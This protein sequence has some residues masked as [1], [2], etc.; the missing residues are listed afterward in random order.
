MNEEKQHEL[1]PMT[2][3]ELLRFSREKKDWTL[4]FV[5]KSINVRSEVLFSIESGETDH[6]PAV[7]L[8]GYIR[9]YARKLDIPS[10][11]IEPHLIEAKGAEPAVQPVFEKGPPRNP[12]DRWFKSTSYVLA[13]AVVI[14]LVWQFTNEA[15]RF[16]QGDPLLRAVGSEQSSNTSNSSNSDEGPE[17]TSQAQQ[18]QTVAKTHL[19]ASI[20][21]LNTTGNQSNS[22]T[23]LPAESAWAAVSNSDTTGGEDAVAYGNDLKINVSADTWVEILDRQGEKIEMD[24]LKAGTSRNYQTNGPLRLLLGRASSVEVIHNGEKINLAPF[25][26]GNVARLTLG[27]EANDSE[28]VSED[29]EST[30]VDSSD[31]DQ[32]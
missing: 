4:Q 21:S 11:E 1:I 7:Y 16:S 22:N 8:K 10:S 19:R 18:P 23:P 9:A 2:L 17:T 12:I 29:S 32:G 28:N 31:P 30:M 25:T 20:A 15:V 26:R 14:A 27:N 24:L 6:L 3:G 5:S 13:S